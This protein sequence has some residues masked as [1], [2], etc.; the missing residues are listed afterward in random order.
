MKKLNKFISLILIFA[1][2]LVFVPLDTIPVHGDTSVTTWDDLKTALQA[3]GTV[4]LGADV[5]APAGD[6]LTIPQDKTVTLDLDGHVIM[7]NDS[8]PDHHNRTEVIMVEG[9]LTLTDSSP[10]SGPRYGYW[11]EADPSEG[12]DIF[13]M[14][15]YYVLTGTA[16]S[17]G[18]Y[19][20]ITGG[21]IAGGSDIINMGCGG[22]VRVRAD[23]AF[24]MDG[25]SIAG[26]AGNGVY[27][28]NK[29]TF[30][31]N[32]GRIVNNI[33]DSD[34]GGVRIQG[35]TFN[36]TGGTIEGNSAS[37]DEGGGVALYSS[38]S[39]E[40]TFTMT[41]GTIKGNTAKKGGGVYVSAINMF[42]TGATFAM[43]DSAVVT[44]NSADCGG[45]VYVDNGTL[46]MLGGHYQRQYRIGERRRRVY[47]SQR[48]G[49]VFEH[50]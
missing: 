41:G 31:M 3:G 43:K 15:R 12:R 4:I 16:P 39:K 20:T 10:T 37:Q 50:H 46:E 18:E 45:G 5:T 44:G 49:S 42:T 35:C 32:D 36:M 14:N 25:G 21:A 7:G 48:D 6:K 29:S 17:L 38:D 19:D 27:A 30:T 9:S 26:C 28:G 23:G 22:G 24:T 1:M 33:S 13:G 34:G 11:R 47:V 8:Q 40:C 2:A